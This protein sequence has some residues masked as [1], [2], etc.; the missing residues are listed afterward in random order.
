[1]QV[2]LVEELGSDAYLYGELVDETSEK[3]TT[4]SRGS[5][6]RRPGQGL[7]GV[8]QIR[9]GKQHVFDATTGEAPPVE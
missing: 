6:P 1:M 4:S 8:V 2:L 7:D 9:E 5:T 3:R